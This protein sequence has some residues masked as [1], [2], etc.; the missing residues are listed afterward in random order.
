VGTKQEEV[1][2]YF[3]EFLELM[4]KDKFLKASS[5]WGSLSLVHGMSPDCSNDGP[6]L[7]A[8]PGEQVV[9]TAD[10]PKSPFKSKKRQVQN[11]SFGAFNP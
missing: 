10:M 5:P 1:G 3:P 6:I 2:D 4:E 9:P 8:R 11:D 7:W